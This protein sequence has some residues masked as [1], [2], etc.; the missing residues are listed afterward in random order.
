MGMA[1][2]AW[3]YEQRLEQ[4]LGKLQIHDLEQP[5]STLSGGERKRV[6]LAFV[7]LEEPDVLILDE[8]TNHLD[9][10]MIE[11]L[12]AFLTRSTMTLLM[13]THDRYFLDRVCNTILEFV[14]RHPLPSQRQLCL[15]PGETGRARGGLLPRR[16]PRPDSFSKKSS[17][18]CDDSPRPRTTK[19]KSR[20]DAFL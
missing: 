1:A 5:I 14:G 3:D 16:W 8:P 19:S 12:E 17:N 13:V 4:I 7:L 11:W 18:G 15:L 2:N 20:I 9:V 6:A 10:E